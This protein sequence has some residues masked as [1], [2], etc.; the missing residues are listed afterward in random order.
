MS[1]RAGAVAYISFV[2][3]F[4]LAPA[5]CKAAESD[6]LADYPGSNI[7]LL[8]MRCDEIHLQP[9]L[10]DTEGWWFYWNFRVVGTQGRTLRFTFDGPNPI[11]RNGPAVSVDEGRTWRWLVAAAVDERETDASFVYSFDESADVKFAFC[12]PY[13]VED[14]AR[15][16]RE[17][18]GSPLRVDC[19]CQTEE[20]RE[21][22]LLRCGE[23]AKRLVLLTARHHACETMAS[24]ALEGCLQAA[25][26]NDQLGHWLQSH[27]E[28]VAVPLMDIDG[29]EA[30]DQGKNRRPHD[31]WLDYSGDSR[32]AEV[33]ALRQW[34]AEHADGRSIVA[35]DF[36]CP[37]VREASEDPGSSERVF[38]M[39]S[40]DAGVAAETS[41]LQSLLE[42]RQRGPLRYRRIHDLGFGVRW[43]TGEIAERSFL[44][45]ASRLPHV[46]AA[47]VLEI[48]YANVGK[49]TVTPDV[50]RALGRDLAVAIRA[51]LEQDL[52]D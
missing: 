20:G 39:N 18:G 3:T 43:N 22:A 21:A 46:K 15:F 31:H 44:G 37:Y 40:M 6:L 2:V 28:I 47:A 23:S 11:G 19:L 35:I 34:V 7:R 51:Y 38:F 42:A 17:Q 13:Q 32:Y 41:L 29:V 33:A 24:F 26:G 52:D 48:P 16:C 1:R 50:A 10:R 4:A 36:H 8:S 14:L 12:V 27:A 30:G 5:A 25:L 45:W 9:D 49:V